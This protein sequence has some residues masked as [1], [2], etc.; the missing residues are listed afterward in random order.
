LVDNDEARATG[1]E[2]L[3]LVRAACVNR[4]L[5]DVA[6][7]YT[8]FQ[9]I[10]LRV[11]EFHVLLHELFDTDRASL[12]KLLFKPEKPKRG[13]PPRDSFYLVALIDWLMESQAIDE[14]SEAISWLRE[15]R[16]EL[17]LS[18]DDL[19]NEKRLANLHAQFAR[20]NRLWS[21]SIYVPPELLT[22]LPPIAPGREA[23][24]EMIESC[25]YTPTDGP[26][27]VR[28]VMIEISRTNKR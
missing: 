12:E 23:P 28:A 14:A 20:L 24:P 16:F 1:L 9:G 22:M 3:E 18:R 4:D 13:R 19:P 11:P 27:E 7:L 2:V 10:V 21:R 25:R 15:H 5:E 6:T 26:L 17:R 8:L